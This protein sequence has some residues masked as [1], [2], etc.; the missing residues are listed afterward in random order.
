MRMENNILEMIQ[1]KE[2]GKMERKMENLLKYHKIIVYEEKGSIFKILGLDNGTMFA[3]Q[4]NRLFRIP[5]TGFKKL[6]N[7]NLNLHKI[8]PQSLNYKKEAIS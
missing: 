8:H 3:A 4:I 1:R 6:P 5:N 2:N 7:K